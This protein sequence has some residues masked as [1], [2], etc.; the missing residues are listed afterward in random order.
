[1]GRLFF[2]QVIFRKRALLLVALLRK[3]T[4]MPMGLRHPLATLIFADIAAIF[5][6][7]VCVSTFTSV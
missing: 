4:H 7:D 6:A 5:V 2:I 3:M 1:M